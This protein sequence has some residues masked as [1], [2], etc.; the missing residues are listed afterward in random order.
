MGALDVTL[1]L[2]IKRQPE[3]CLGAHGRGL[4]RDIDLGVVTAEVTGGPSTDAWDAQV[5]RGEASKGGKEVASGRAEETQRGGQVRR[6]CRWAGDTP[7]LCHAPPG[8]GGTAVVR[9]RSFTGHTLTS[10][11]SVLSPGG[12]EVCH[13]LCPQGTA[14]RQ[15]GREDRSGGDAGEESCTAPGSGQSTARCGPCAVRAA[16]RDSHV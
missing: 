1:G 2:R 13:S 9:I 12:L 11:Y 10:S 4:R 3:A 5:G 14:S 7:C 16:L 6:P 8:K 15:A